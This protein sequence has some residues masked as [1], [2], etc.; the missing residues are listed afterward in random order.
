MLCLYP[1]FLDGRRGAYERLPTVI[2]PSPTP[3]VAT[4]PPGPAPASPGVATTPPGPAS[5]SPGPAPV[6]PGSAPPTVWQLG[7]GSLWVRRARVEDGGFYLCQASNGVGADLSKVVQLT[8]HGE[9]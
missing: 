9:C 3:G 2:R 6:S 4:T 8:V 1:S 5:A 7:N